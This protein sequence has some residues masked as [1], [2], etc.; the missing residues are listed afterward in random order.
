MRQ[1]NSGDIKVHV[2]NHMM[3]VLTGD[4]QFL[5]LINTVFPPPW[6]ADLE[7]EW[8]KRKA[9]RSIHY[10]YTNWERIHGADSHVSRGCLTHSMRYP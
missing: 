4:I 1:L 10:E 3:N 2:Q 5:N 8:R 7:P 6:R 9:S